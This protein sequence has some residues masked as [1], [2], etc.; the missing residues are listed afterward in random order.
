MSWRCDDYPSLLHTIPYRMLQKC[1]GPCNVFAV[2]A[3]ASHVGP[4]T[5]TTLEDREAR[6]EASGVLGGSGQSEVDLGISQVGQHR[7]EN[8]LGRERGKEQPPN[9]K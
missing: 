7:Q 4:S 2:T 6:L 3:P 8:G 1:L 5:G 9:I